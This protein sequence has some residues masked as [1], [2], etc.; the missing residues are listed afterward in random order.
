MHLGAAG[1]R[2]GGPRGRVV[3]GVPA[4]RRRWS[5]TTAPRPRPTARTLEQAAADG[6][7]RASSTSSSSGRARE[8]ARA[9]AGRLPTCL[10]IRVAT[11]ADTLD[12]VLAAGPAHR[13]RA[14]RLRPAGHDGAAEDHLRRLAEHPHRLVLRAVRRR[15][16]A[17]VPRGQPNLSGDELRD[18]LARAHAARAR[19]GHPRDRRRGRAEA[20]AAYAETGA[21]RLDRARAAGRPRRRHGRWPSSASAPACSRRTC[22]TTATSPSC[23]ARP[24][25]ALLRVPLDAR[26]RGRGGAR[27]ATPR[28]R[29]STR[30]WRSRPRCT[31]A[32]TTGDPWH[33]EQALTAAR[34]AGRELRR[35][36]TVDAGHPADLVLLDADPL[37]AAAPLAEPGRT[38]LRADARSPRPGSTGGSLTPGSEARSLRLGLAAARARRSARGCVRGS[39][40]RSPNSSRS[41]PMR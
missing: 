41:W 38:A 21:A 1:A 3:R 8:L 17:R 16:P 18:L 39:S 28:S 4:A 35:A 19:G 26:R 32:P 14:A 36:G 9:R 6:R 22:S 7:R 25:R 13:R 29:R 5:A 30:G 20:L 31:A 12:D 24:R 23:L 15:A 11:Y 40:S 10:R 37:A 27:A 2:L 34:G 33:A